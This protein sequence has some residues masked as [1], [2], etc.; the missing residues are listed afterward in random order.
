MTEREEFEADAAPYDYD[1]TRAECG[2]CTYIDPATEDRW[3]GWQACAELKDKRIKEFERQ[4]KTAHN[5][6]LEEVIA[7]HEWLNTDAGA[8][9]TNSIR[10]MKEK[11][12]PYGYFIK[13]NGAAAQIN[14]DS[15]GLDGVDSFPLYTR[16]VP[17]RKLTDEEKK[18]LVLSV[19]AELTPNSVSPLNSQG[20]YFTVTPEEMYAIIAKAR[21]E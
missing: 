11:F 13:H 8:W 14:A 18:S 3:L 2:C 1:F 4:L 9:L 10:D 7:T 12:E 16:P 17:L 20:D 21:G 6:T 15:I 19:C 5:D